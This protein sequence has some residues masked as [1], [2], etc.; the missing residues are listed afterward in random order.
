MVEFT[1]FPS[2]LSHSGRLA[3]TGEIVMVLMET[4]LLDVMGDPAPEV[5][6]ILLGDVGII[7]FGCTCKSKSLAFE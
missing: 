7:L 5:R 1:A 3:W 4:L 6:Y 2:P